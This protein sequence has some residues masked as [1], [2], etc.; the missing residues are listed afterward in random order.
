MSQ[1]FF[2]IYGI[3]QTETSMNLRERHS[4]M[5]KQGVWELT[6]NTSI[7]EE[8]SLIR[9]KWV[10]KQKKNEMYRAKLVALGYS[11]VPGVD[12]SVSYA[13]VLPC[14]SNKPESP[15]VFFIG[16]KLCNR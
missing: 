15:A 5:I 4:D 8:Q 9:N 1:D 6:D 16:K 2:I 7:P 12:F 10:F 11:Q 13:P 3:I 14:I